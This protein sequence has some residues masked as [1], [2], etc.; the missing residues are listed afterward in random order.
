MKWAYLVSFVNAAIGLGAG[1]GMLV[2]CAGRL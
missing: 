2:A 1:A